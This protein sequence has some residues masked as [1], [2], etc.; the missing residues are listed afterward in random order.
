MRFF[1]KRRYEIG[2][3]ETSR[4]A[5]IEHVLHGLLE[6]LGANAIA[7][8]VK[9][10]QAFGSQNGGIAIRFARRASGNLRERALNDFPANLR[11]RRNLPRKSGRKRRKRGHRRLLFVKPGILAVA[12]PTR[13]QSRACQGFALALRNA[14]IDR[15]GVARNHFCGAFRFR[16]IK[17]RGIKRATLQKA[18]CRGGTLN[19]PKRRF[20]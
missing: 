14:R 3:V 15:D 18:A 16:T 5:R 20:G 2:D 6:L 10:K 9:E 4:L 1:L 8:S 11:A 19:D 12:E 13:R 7:Q 17:K